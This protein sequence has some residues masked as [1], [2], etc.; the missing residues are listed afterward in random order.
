MVKAGKP[1]D[2]N[3]T[4]LLPFLDKVDLVIDGGNSFFKDTN[5]RGRALAAKGLLYLGLGVS[6]GETGARRGPSLM[7]GGPPEA[8]DRMRPILEAAAAKVQGEPCVTYLGSGSAGHYVKMV[9]NGIEYAV[10]ELLAEA[11]DL[12]RRGLG[13]SPRESAG[14]YEEW[15]RGELASYLVEITAPILRRVE[16]KTG[17]PLIDLVLDQARQ[18]GTGKWT[19]QEAMDLQVPTP[20]IDTAVMMRDLSGYKAAREAASRVLQG[21]S[22]GFQGERQ[23]FI[24]QMGRSLYAAMALAFA[25]GMALLQRASQ[26]YDYHLQLSEVARIWRGGCII[27]AALLEDIRAAYR[28]Q[29]DLPHLLLD[30]HLGS[31]VMARMPDLRTVAAAAAYLGIPAPGLMVSLAYYDAWR[32][33]RLPANLIQAQRDYFGAHTY[34]RTDLPGTFHTQWIA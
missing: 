9:H 20:T 4:T 21:P 1:V 14:I 23:T 33:A 6:G 22:P 17:Q 26:V 18:K 2:E 16:E 15:N 29:P 31:E 34:Q 10:M 28:A 32:S 30:P 13:L 5:R 27:R 3:I 11:Y 12:L 24:R 7:P 25:Q 8:Y 19:S